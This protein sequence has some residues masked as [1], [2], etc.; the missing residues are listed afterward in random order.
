MQ[1]SEVRKSL[2]GLTAM[3][4]TCEKCQGAAAPAAQMR[5]FE[6]EGQTLHCLSL[7]SVCLVCGHCW[8]DDTYESENLLFEEQA[9]EA[10]S[11]RRR[12]SHEH[13]CAEKVAATTSHRQG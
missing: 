1:S 2:G 9:R 11:R 3:A 7:V 6:Y 12:Y 5:R 4:Q 8:E 13:T 10:A